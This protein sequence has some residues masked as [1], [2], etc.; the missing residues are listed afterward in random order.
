MIRPNDR[1]L[2]NRRTPFL[3]VK[4]LQ[5]REEACVDFPFP[6]ETHTPFWIGL[7]ALFFL[8][9]IFLQ[10]LFWPQGNMPPLIA[11]FLFFFVEIFKT[12]YFF[13]LYTFLS[14]CVN[15]QE[16]L[17]FYI[18]IINEKILRPLESEKTV[19]TKMS[20]S[21]CLSVVY[22][23]TLDRIIGLNWDLAYFIGAGK[24]R[25]SSLTSHI[26]EK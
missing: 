9:T 5:T 21:V 17:I 24:V 25:T 13:I 14:M 7:Q 26:Q 12:F 4:T 2:S 22:S 23:I 15:V 1:K 16:N 8:Y 18:L 19:F 10:I 11:I 3:W 20:V 6:L